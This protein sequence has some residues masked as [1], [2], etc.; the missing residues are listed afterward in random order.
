M[1]RAVTQTSDVRRVAITLAERLSIPSV[2]FA[3]AA[4]L[5]DMLGVPK[6]VAAVESFLRR[7]YRT[8]TRGALRGKLIAEPPGSYDAWREIPEDQ[9]RPGHPSVIY[10]VEDVWP[11]LLLWL[12]ERRST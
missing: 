5:A 2:R 7:R 11:V 9:R 1:E 10:V 12:A 6:Q 3:S 4:E 8:H